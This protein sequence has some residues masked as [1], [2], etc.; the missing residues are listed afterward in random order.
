MIKEKVLEN[1]YLD[2]D[3]KI[4]IERIIKENRKIF[5]ILYKY[6]KFLYK[7]QSEFNNYTMNL[8]TNYHFS[9]FIQ[10]HKLYQSAIIMIEYG[11]LESFET[12]LRNILESTVNIL[13]SLIDNKNIMI[14]ELDSID[15]DLKK[16]KYIDN[17]K[18]FDVVSKEKVDEYR[19]QKEEERAKI[20]NEI[21]DTKK[22]MPI[23]LFKTINF[24]KEYLYYKCLCDYT[25][26][27]S[28]IAGRIVKQ[29][30]DGFIFDGGPNYLDINNESARLI[31]TIELF[32]D[33]FIKKYS[34]NLIEEYKAL[35]KEADAL[36]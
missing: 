21:G 16:L 1:G 30:T 27:N 23:G 29:E 36:N 9:M 24:E 32:I 19:K 8:E 5:E 17:N 7:I 10:I 3:Y 11:L 2:D 34:P 18:I 35:E 22:P 31:G 12:I 33:K 20:I 14:L 6:N 15:E 28:N 13:Y 4:M 26:M 25:H